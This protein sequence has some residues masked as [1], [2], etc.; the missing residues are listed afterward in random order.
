MTKGIFSALGALVIVTLLGAVMLTACSKPVPAVN[1]YYAVAFG[2]KDGRPFAELGLGHVQDRAT[3]EKEAKVAEGTLLQ[4]APA[5]AGITVVCVPVP[6]GPRS[7]AAPP[8]PQQGDDEGDGSY[9]PSF[10]T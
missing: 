6:D 4:G 8:Q 7:L 3:C 2:Y 5:G 9:R 10:N 1:G